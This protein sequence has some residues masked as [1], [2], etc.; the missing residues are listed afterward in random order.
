MTHI[1]DMR[2]RL[3]DE[4]CYRVMSEYTR[5]NTLPEWRG[6]LLRVMYRVAELKRLEPIE[7]A[8]HAAALADSYRRLDIVMSWYGRV[9]MPQWFSLLGDSWSVCDNISRWRSTLRTILRR[10]TR[11]ELDFMMDANECE[12]LADLPEC[13]TVYRGCYPVNRAGLSWTMD[14]T[15]AERF[16][17]LNRYRLRDQQPLLRTGTVR[18]DRIVLKLCRN[19]RE[20][21]AHHVRILK[22]EAI[23]S[24]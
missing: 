17:T 8:R 24:C 21:I 22:E 15:V 20:V 9:A 2:G 12:S 1:W 3:G 16:P 4:E 13:I 7:Q 10:A 11:E 14:R 19:E 23:N 18:R 5:A 6:V